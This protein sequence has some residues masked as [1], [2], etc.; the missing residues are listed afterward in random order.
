MNKTISIGRKKI[1]LHQPPFIIAELSANHNGS[2][3]RALDIISM[4]KHMGADAIK[5]QTYT[6]DTLTIDSDE[7]DFKITSG[8]W[9]GYTLHQLYEKAHT[10]FEWH[11]RLFDHARSEDIICFSSPFDESAVDLLED[12]NTPAYKVASF[13][14][15]DLAL[16]RYVAQTKKPMIISTGMAN[17]KEIEE[18]VETAKNAGCQDV[19]LLHCISGYPTPYDQS[20]I[21]TLADLSKRFGVVSGLSDHTLG[22]AVS[23]AAVALG[24]KVI[25]KHVTL[26][27]KDIGPDSSFSLEPSELKALCT[28]SKIAWSCLG[29]AGYERKAVEQESMKF[30][31]SLYVVKDVAQGQIITSKDVRSIRPGFGLAP[32]FIDNILGRRASQNLKRGTALDWSHVET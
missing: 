3:D 12:L 11:K 20:N 16:I 10:P 18:A 14:A 32:K 8:L 24:A 17:L 30:R 31:R 22:T 15:I 2:I 13:E 27:R 5:L 7:A 25:E 4:A 23:V 26:S 28:E 6:A 19:I 21:R 29:E 1:G 9:K